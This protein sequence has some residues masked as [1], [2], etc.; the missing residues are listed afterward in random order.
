GSLRRDEGGPGRFLHSLAE[1]WTHGA[2]VDWRA[3][4]GGGRPVALPTYPFQ[5][6]PY[7]LEVRSD[8]PAPAAPAA[9]AFWTAVEDGDPAGLTAPATP[10][11]WRAVLPCLAAWRPERRARPQPGAWRSR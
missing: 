6:R 3:A 2:P 11:A 4:P 7:R 1:A 10:D 5:R 9:A 8:E